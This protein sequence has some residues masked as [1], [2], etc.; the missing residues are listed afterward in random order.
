MG[1]IGKSHLYLLKS[2]YGKVRIMH[3]DRVI[4]LLG[5][6]LYEMAD[7]M[8]EATNW[9]EEYNNERSHGA[10]DGLTPRAFA[11]QCSSQSW[12]HAA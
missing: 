2:Q 5:C 9:L 6:H 7:A 4:C 1:H 8:I 3:L 11:A 10:L 12:Q